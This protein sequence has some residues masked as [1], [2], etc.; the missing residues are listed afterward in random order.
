MHIFYGVPGKAITE[1]VRLHVLMLRI[2]AEGDFNSGN[3]IY[4]IRFV[5]FHYYL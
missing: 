4:H 1:D 3:N 5:S 2:H